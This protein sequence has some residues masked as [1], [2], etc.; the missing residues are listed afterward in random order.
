MNKEITTKQKTT[1]NERKKPKKETQS[2]GSYKRAREGPRRR[3]VRLNH[4]GPK[5]L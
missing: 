1:N 4:S 5:G 3:G 2:V